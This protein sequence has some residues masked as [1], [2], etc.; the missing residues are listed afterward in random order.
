VAIEIAELVA[1]VRAHTTEFKEGM[2][3]VEG[4]M[5]KTQKAAG[6][7]GLAI[8]GGLAYGLDKSI[9]AAEEG[10]VSQSHLD[11]AFK[12]AGQ[13][14]DKYS[15]QIDEA[16]SS[17]RKLGFTNDDTRGSLATLETATHD[18][19]KSFEL[20]GT[21][22]DLSRT[23]HESLDAASSTLAKAMTGSARAAKAL[24][25]QI[26]PATD[27]MDALGSKTDYASLKQYELAKT[28]A[29]LADKQE[30]ASQVIDKVTAATKGQ[31][32]AFSHTAAGGMATFHAQVNEVEEGLGNALL[33]ALT[34]VTGAIAAMAGWL[35]EHEG[36][37]KL[38][39]AALG[40]LAGALLATS[41]A[42]TI[43]NSALLASPITWIILGLIALVAA[44]VYAYE[45]F[46]TF[47]DIVQAVMGGV[48]EAVGV[49]V[50]AVVATFNF[51]KDTV[52]AIWG[53]IGGD[54]RAAWALIEGIVKLYLGIL[55][56]EV[57]GVIAIVETVVR[58]GFN[59][60]KDI[61]KIVMDLIHGDWSGAWNAM[62]ALVSDVLGGIEGVLKIAVGTVESIAKQIGTALLNAVKDKAGDLLDF[63]RS[64][65]GRL[66]AALG[67]LGSL[68]IHAGESLIDG[69]VHGVESKISAVE[70]TL[71]SLTSKLTSWKGPPEKD[72]VILEPAGRSVMQGFIDGVTAKIPQVQDLMQGV[73]PSLNV[74]DLAPAASATAHG[75]VTV[76]VNN[77]TFL[78]GSRTELRQFANTLQEFLA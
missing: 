37:T 10:Q 29:T 60:I 22:E 41:V 15:G 33:P 34:K 48:R 52:N 7:A 2:H 43:M 5:T 24:G 54:V 12:A 13:S 62:K 3:E 25:I 39:V 4:G 50:N 26:I 19:R 57:R 56:T 36:V 67:D 74:G 78:S 59:A 38:V 18:A 14:A 68:L 44:V 30:T 70:G 58:T 72:A 9:E 75:G 17:G 47:H 28:A 51:L 32:D 21:A 40:L 71:K 46:Q 69:F 1:E 55:E 61:I 45:H 42:T 6:I 35:S 31:A 53:A 64:L 20:L 49:A 27:H 65:P 23:K 76:Q 16:E 73:A 8:A 63:M 77:P 11:A 66:V